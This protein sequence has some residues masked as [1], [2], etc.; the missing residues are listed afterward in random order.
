MRIVISMIVWLALC[1]PVAVRSQEDVEAKLTALKKE[2][3]GRQG[4]VFEVYKGVL[5]EKPKRYGWELE[6]DRNYHV[7]VVADVALDDIMAQAELYREAV[8][9]PERVEVD[10]V[11]CYLW[12]IQTFA[13]GSRNIVVQL[14]NAGGGGNYAVVLASSGRQPTPPERVTRAYD[15]QGFC[16]EIIGNI[17][18]RNG[19]KHYENKKFTLVSLCVAPN[20]TLYMLTSEGAAL[21]INGIIYKG[22]ASHPEQ[23]VVK[24]VVT[25]DNR[26]LLL[27]AD[28]SVLDHNGHTTFR[29]TGDDV[30]VDLIQ[31]RWNVWI[32][33]RNGKRLKP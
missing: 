21:S 12:Q 27:R 1:L 32:I 23:A 9:A 25:L 17:V 2:I 20:G 10:G 4:M 7:W 18:Y 6:R 14:R 30:V 26:V 16:Y 19:M 5:A 22:S 11:A 13:S 28:S 29:R 24:I 8:L 33:C 3:A 31:E 15:A